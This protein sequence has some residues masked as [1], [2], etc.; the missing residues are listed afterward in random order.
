MKPRNPVAL[1][2]GWIA[3]ASVPAGPSA[4]AE[5]S[6]APPARVGE[7]AIIGIVTNAGTGRTLEGARVVLVGTGRETLTDNQGAF[8]FSGVAPGSGVL[9]VSYTGLNTIDIPVTVAPGRL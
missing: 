3:L 8:R 1:L 9:S 6:T 4:A 2:I 7:E 5:T